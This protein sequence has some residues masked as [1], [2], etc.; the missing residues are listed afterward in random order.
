MNL[1]GHDENALFSCRQRKL[2]VTRIKLEAISRFVQLQC[3]KLFN[4][5]I[6]LYNRLFN[7]N[8]LAQ[9]ST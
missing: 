7:F 6:Y 8:G 4:Q 5:R 2:R 1:D 3:I 9:Y